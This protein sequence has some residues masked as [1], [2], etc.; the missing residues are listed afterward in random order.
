MDRND[1]SNM[2]LWLELPGKSAEGSPQ[3]KFMDVVKEDLKVAD[4]SEEDEMMG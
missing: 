1:I 3:R 4:V 2:L